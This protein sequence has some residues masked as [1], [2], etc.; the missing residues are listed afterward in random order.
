MS[1]C[2]DRS[3]GW[4]EGKLRGKG[5]PSTIAAAKLNTRRILLLNAY[6]I[7]HPVKLLLV[8]VGQLVLITVDDIS[9]VMIADREEYTSKHK[10]LTL[11]SFT[12]YNE[13]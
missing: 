11:I 7:V 5:R 2:N 10:I 13:E 9:V 1:G 4:S 3:R 6:C 12:C 8:G